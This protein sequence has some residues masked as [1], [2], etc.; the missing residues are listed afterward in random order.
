MSFLNPKYQEAVQ[1]KRSTYGIRKVIRLYEEKNDE[2]IIPRGAL[3]K[4]LPLVGP[5]NKIHNNTAIFKKVDIPSKIEMRPLQEPWIEDML[6]HFQGV[7]VAP[8]GSGKTVMALEVI[9]RL[10]Q[11]T[12]WLTHRQ[13]L[14]EQFK[15]RAGFFIGGG[16][17][18][19]I[20]DGKY[21]IGKVLTAGMIQ[22]LI[23]R[24]LTELS[25]K[26]GL[27]ILD[28]GHI[29]P[30]EQTMEVIRKFAPQY[31]Y[32]LTATP[33]REDKLEQIMF[34]T[35]GPCIAYLDRQEVVD[36]D[37]IMPAK[38]LVRKTGVTHNP[39]IHSRYDKIIKYLT[40]HTARNILILADVLTEIALGNICILLTNRVEHGKIIKRELK[41]LGVDSVHIHAKTTNKKRKEYTAQ[42]KSGEVALMIATYSLLKEG[43]DHKPTNRIFFALPHK[44]KGIIEQAKGRIE[45]TAPG[46]TNAVVYDY[47]DSI[48]MLQR[49]FEMRY[50]QYQEHNL[51]M[52]DSTPL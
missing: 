45:R 8:P 46:K 35:I 28:E 48:P 15:E 26:F 23:K 11:P 4:I 41:A 33:Y 17:V 24:D 51:V 37:G 21:E 49:Q 20:G 10:G 34:D 14:V 52:I 12:L 47:V 27:I 32:G 9:A 38:I 2:L 36:A 3:Y 16:D 1:F 42:F 39:A 6:K 19:I 31:L 7:G 29:C 13:G 43:F 18:G 44:A 5:P 30:A 25:H 40:T 50:E 22:T